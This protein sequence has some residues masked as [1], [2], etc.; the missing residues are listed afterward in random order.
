MRP[1]RIFNFW[2]ANQNETRPAYTGRNSHEL[3]RRLSALEPCSSKTW[4]LPPTQALRNNEAEEVL[5]FVD[6]DR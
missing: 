5:S 2:L 1:I 4:A 3:G 6:T